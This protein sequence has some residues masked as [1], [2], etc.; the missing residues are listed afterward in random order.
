[1]QGA[2]LIV[3][4]LSQ[5]SQIEGHGYLLEPSP[6]NVVHKGGSRG[7]GDIQSLAGGGPAADQKVGHGLCGDTVGRQEFTEGNAYGATAPVATY[8]QGQEVEF[9]VKITAHHWGWFE[10]RL[11]EPSD[12]GQTTILPLLKSA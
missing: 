9:K 4:L 12:G 8:V 2:T 6:R 5:L 1:M 11:C 3:F 7:N 10:F